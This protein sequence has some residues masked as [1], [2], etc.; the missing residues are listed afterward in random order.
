MKK[1]E[2]WIFVLTTV[3][4]TMLFSF[5]GQHF[6]PYPGVGEVVGVVCGISVGIHT[7]LVAA[8]VL[9]KMRSGK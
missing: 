4:W 9:T 3:C 7:W 1:N 2:I 5:I 8:S 6:I